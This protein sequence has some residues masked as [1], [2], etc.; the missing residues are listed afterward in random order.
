MS[1]VKGNMLIIDD[2]VIWTLGGASVD[3]CGDR[4]AEPTWVHN[5]VW[6]S[7]TDSNSGDQYLVCMLGICNAS[8][9][10]ENVT[11]WQPLSASRLTSLAASA[12][13]K[14]GKMPHGMNRPG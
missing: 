3:T 4:D 2:A 5:T 9:F 7:Q 11:A 6:F 14:S 13:S 8:G 1:S 10:S 12:T